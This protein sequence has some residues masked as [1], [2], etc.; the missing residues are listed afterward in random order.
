MGN[1]DLL[2]FLKFENSICLQ[3]KKNEFKCSTISNHYQLT[4]LHM[5]PTIE[6]DSTNIYV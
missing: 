2:S 1:R 5:V 6:L 4:E 3:L